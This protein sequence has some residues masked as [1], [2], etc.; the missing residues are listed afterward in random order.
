MHAQ[1]AVRSE[2]LHGQQV[3]EETNVC[4]IL[5]PIALCFCHPS[6][7]ANGS[8]NKPVGEA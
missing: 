6:G 4:Y 3:S 2:W 1:Y 7:M 5:V 8:P